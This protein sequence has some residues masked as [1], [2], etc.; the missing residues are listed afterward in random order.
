MDPGRA[1]FRVPR[2]KFSRFHA[3]FWIF[4]QN[5]MLMPPSPRRIVDP[6]THHSTWH[7][8]L[9]FNT[10]S[11]LQ[12][13]EICSYPINVCGGWVLLSIMVCFATYVP[14]F[15][16]L[17]HKAQWPELDINGCLPENCMKIKNGPRRG[18]YVPGTPLD[19]PKH[20]TIFVTCFQFKEAWHSVSRRVV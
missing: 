17:S 7:L 2:L 12:Y 15:I 14:N 4:L 1:N 3:I 6:P 5:R 8:Y 11:V 10:Y 20:C 18:T 19:L 9:I 13:L 16:I